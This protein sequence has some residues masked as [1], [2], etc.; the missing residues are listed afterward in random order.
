MKID[1]ESRQVYGDN[2]KYLKTK[3]KIYANSI[4]TNFHKNKITKE[5][6]PCKCLSIIMLDSVVK[7]NKIYY[8]ETPLEECKYEQNKVKT[9]NCINEDL[10]KHE[11]DSDCN[12]GT[13]SDIDNDSNDDETK[14][15]IDND[16]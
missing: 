11:S 15:D 6:A 5:K 14:S 1:S 9:E 4:I 3:I 2:D 12:N 7:A 16:Q 13:E 8:P 10:E